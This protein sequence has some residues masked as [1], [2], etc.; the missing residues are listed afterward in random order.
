MPKKN[1]KLFFFQVGEYTSL[2]N[3]FN[4]YKKCNLF[5]QIYV[6]KICRAYLIFSHTDIVQN[7]AHFRPKNTRLS[8]YLD[9]VM[10][11]SLTI[12]SKNVF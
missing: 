11:I 4:F 1:F 3:K 2:Q 7:I 5:N 9:G 10:V 8:A 12:N 6:K